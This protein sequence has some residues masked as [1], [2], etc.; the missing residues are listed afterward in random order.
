MSDRKEMPSAFLDEV[1]GETEEIAKP[2]A[3]VSP[4]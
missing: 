4:Q 2:K 1:C 3:T